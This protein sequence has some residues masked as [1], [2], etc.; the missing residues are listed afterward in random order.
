MQALNYGQYRKL[1]ARPEM[2]KVAKALN[3]VSSALDIKYVVVGGAAVY[4][5]VGNPPIDQPDIDIM[6][7]ADAN[8]GK[9][10]IERLVR[11][12]FDVVFYDYESPDDMFAT[13][14]YGAVEVDIFTSQES[15]AYTHNAH[16]S[17]GWPLEPIE[18]L[19]VEKI[20]RSST[21]DILMAIDLLSLGIHD[22][23]R[24]YSLS[25]QYLRTGKVRLLERVANSVASRKI[26]KAA[27]R[28]L[29]EQ[30]SFN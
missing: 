17:G 29:A 28:R 20:V 19:I 23:P 1:F 6:L 15:R 4:L 11:R 9:V 12:G 16:K 7:D 24:L 5:Y 25:A 21:A 30:M 8:T 13:V 14:R 26:N 22:K 18:A 10:F 27:L 3:E 2:P